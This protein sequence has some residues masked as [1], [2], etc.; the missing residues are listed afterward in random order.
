[1]LFIPLSDDNPLKFLRYQ[2]VTVGIIAANVLVFILQLSGLGLAAG[3]SFAVV[4]AELIGVG[5]VSGAAHGPYDAIPVPEVATLI[6]YMFL[7]ADVVHLASNM[8]F[9]WVFGDNVEDAMGHVR[10]LLFY[11]LCGIAG[12]LAQTA[13]EPQSQLPLIGASGAVAGTI[14]AYL[15]LHPRVLVWVLAFRVIPLRVTATWILGLWV[16]TQFFMVLIN[17]G[18][19][20]AWWAHIG[21]ALAGGVLVVLMRRPT[22]ALF[23][24]GAAPSQERDAW[25]RAYRAGLLHRGLLRLRNPVRWTR[26]LARYLRATGNRLI[27]WARVRVADLQGAW[28]TRAKSAK[29][30]QAGAGAGAEA[31]AGPGAQAGA[32]ASAP[33]RRRTADIL[34]FEPRGENFA[35]VR[36]EADGSRSE[37]VL[38][39]ANVVHLGLLAPG[40]SRQ[41]LTDKLGRQPGTVA[42][43]VR[44]GA[45][46]ANLR[47]IEALLTILDRGGARLDFS[48]TERRTRALASRL[49]ERA[50]RIANAPAK[51][52]KDPR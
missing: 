38:T 26:A 16:A 11:L 21:G 52:A 7:H 25:W 44:S 18:D 6:T 8:M 51:P 30:S 24:R 45:M 34:A 2:W 43:I 36:L 33:A 39:T 4:P 5:L 47:F 31:E 32:P 50:D 19:Y 1:L 48:T 41:V 35:L 27:R 14:A 12:A 22:V 3:T 9:L 40:F 42:A 49:M 37:I 20:V 28:S 10:Y 29:A 13:M 46:N 23:D 17:R 15:I